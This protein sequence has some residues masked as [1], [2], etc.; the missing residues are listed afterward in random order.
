L[1]TTAPRWA[2]ERLGRGQVVEHP[3]RRRGYARAGHQPLG[4][5]LRSFDLGRGARRPEERDPRRHHRVAQARHQRRLGPAHHQVDAG[6]QRQ[7]GELVDR[8]GL[9]DVGRDLRLGYPGDARVAGRRGDAVT[10]RASRQLPGQRVLAP[11]RTDQENVKAH[12]LDLPT[13]NLR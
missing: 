2:S 12:A 3:E 11:A 4:V 6:A 13:A 5:G 1:T 7:R 8:L 10:Q 9:H